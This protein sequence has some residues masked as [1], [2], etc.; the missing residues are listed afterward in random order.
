MKTINILNKKDLK[1]KEN[2]TKI[3]GK[4]IKIYCDLDNPKNINN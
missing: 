1:I 4:M 2:I 3:E